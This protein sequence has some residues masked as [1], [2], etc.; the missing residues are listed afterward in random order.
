[1]VK[2]EKVC[3]VAKGHLCWLHVC[4]GCGKIHKVPP[5]QALRISECSK[6]RYPY[7]AVYAGPAEEELLI[8]AFGKQYKDVIA[9]DVTEHSGFMKRLEREFERAKAAR[10]SEYVFMLG[11]DLRD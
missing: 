5:L 1:M 3:S 4:F 6:N 2:K 9:K 8:R 7:L 10:N 11:L